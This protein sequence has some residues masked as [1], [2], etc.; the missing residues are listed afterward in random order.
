MCLGS[1]TCDEPLDIQL[2]LTYE[3]LLDRKKHQ[4]GTKTI[5]LVKI[6]WWN[7]GVEEATRVLEQQMQEWF[8]HLFE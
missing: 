1:L 3:E 4:M 5:P 7:H 8:S 6:L 2:K